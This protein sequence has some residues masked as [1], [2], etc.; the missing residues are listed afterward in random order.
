[1]VH[2]QSFFIFQIHI[3][4]YSSCTFMKYRWITAVKLQFIQATSITVSLK[5][6]T[7]LDVPLVT[8]YIN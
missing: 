4:L 2:I 7:L 8:L 1:M 6:S 5:L 3:V